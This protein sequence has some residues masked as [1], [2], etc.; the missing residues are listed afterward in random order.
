MA[1]TQDSR[2]Y[3]EFRYTSGCLTCVVIVWALLPAGVG[4]AVLGDM[5]LGSLR[6]HR[7]PLGI[8]DLALLGVPVLCGLPFVGF[9]LLRTNAFLRI[10]K[11]G[12][13]Y[14]NSLRRETS[15]KWEQI[16]GVHTGQTWLAPWCLRYRRDAH[17]EERWLYI[18]SPRY[19]GV[20]APRSVLNTILAETRLR[21]RVYSYW[22]GPGWE[23]Q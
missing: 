13:Y 16:V 23:R 18:Q 9:L 7:P 2:A 1:E 22:W 12:I 21:R 6:G 4:L 20:D 10:S 5:V 11:D 14:F 3:G 8:A 19:L 17:S 15:L